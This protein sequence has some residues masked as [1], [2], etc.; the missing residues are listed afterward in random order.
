MKQD[1]AMQGYWFVAAD[2]KRPSIAVDDAVLVGA[3]AWWRTVAMD[4]VA[5]GGWFGDGVF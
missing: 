1:D 4:G 5:D 2:E 3:Q